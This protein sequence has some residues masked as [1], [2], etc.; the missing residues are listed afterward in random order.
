[1]CGVHTTAPVPKNRDGRLWRRSGGDR[2]I[3]RA[4][5]TEEE[6]MRER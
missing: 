6:G 2:G 4:G 3:E 5:T 1:M